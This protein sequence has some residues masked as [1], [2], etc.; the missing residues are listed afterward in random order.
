MRARV[1][2]VRLQNGYLHLVEAK[3]VFSLL[4]PSLN[5]VLV[6]VDVEACDPPRH[7]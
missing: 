1:L 4:S 2:S 5:D 7:T 6:T 3:V